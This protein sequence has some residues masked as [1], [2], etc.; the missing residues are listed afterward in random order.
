[1][2]ILVTV[3][4]SE[5][6]FD[7][8]IEAIAPLCAEHD[9]FAQ[10]G[11]SKRAPPCAHSP[12]IPYPEMI[13]RIRAADIVITHA[14]NTVRLV[15]RAGKVPVAIARTGPSEMANDHQVEYLRHEARAGRVVAVWDL[16][17]LPQVVASHPAEEARLL[18]ERALDPPAAAT[19]TAATF[20]AEWRRLA[21][22]PFK[23]H[24][25]RR[26]AYAWEELAT[27]CGRHLDFGCQT[28]EFLAVLAAT[29]A[30]DCHGIDPH[31]G[32]LR[33]A[34]RTYPDIPFDFV[35]VSGPVPCPAGHFDSVSLLDTLEHCP[36]EDAVLSEIRRVLR[37]DGLLVL[38]VPASHVF[39]FLD[40]DAVK[41]RL[42]RLHRLI[43][44][45]RFGRE[46]Y[47]QRFVDL[48]D[49]LFGDMSL[50]KKDHTHYRK[51]WLV[52]RLRAHGFVVTRASG[53]N[54]FWRFF[55][56]PALLCKPGFLQRQ[57][58]RLIWLDGRL[59]SSANL[60][61]SARLP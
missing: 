13:E 51:D 9:V 28:G 26:Y 32:Y 33:Q 4:M 56:A 44:S 36:D 14:G 57:L 7:R 24:H 25:L 53:A 1:M 31:R 47:H 3:G 60:F 49:G 37:P 39:S 11:T 12:F 61:L 41:F 2:K 8:L 18:R 58:E 21:C 42:P 43:Y 29:T 50:G 54:L 59:F 6:P 5:W 15:Q 38:T 46:L 34:A 30:L 17:R 19:E 45:A 22:N 40:P 48:G 20:D 23:G 10:T 55:Q 52:E 27:R 16:G 35:P